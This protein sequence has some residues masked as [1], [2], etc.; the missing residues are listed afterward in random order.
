MPAFLLFRLYGPLVSWGT[1]AVG[2]LRPS[3]THPTRSAVLG[4]VGACLGL[5]RADEAGQAALAEGYGIAIRIDALGAPVTDYHT[6]QAPPQKRGFAPRSRREELAV[7]QKETMVT[8]RTYRQDALSTIAIWARDGAR[9]PLDAVADVMRR[10]VFMPYLGRK[11][12]PLALP[13]DPQLVEAAGLLAAF[14]AADTL[15]A[16]DE[17]LRGLARDPAPTLCWD[18]DPP[19][20]PLPSG[21]ET[22]RRDQPVSRTRWQ[23]VDRVEHVAIMGDEG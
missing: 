3:D 14:V 19:G 21:R 8:R 12:C 10:P 17:L 2:E 23:F 13:L 15:F 7:E 6:V 1:Q 20:D 22:L 5:E 18:A 9:W 11:G 16:D 4:L